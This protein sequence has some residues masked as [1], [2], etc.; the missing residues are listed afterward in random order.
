MD[1]GWEPVRNGDIYCSPR[2]GGKCKWD[3]YTHACDEAVTLAAIMKEA[4]GLDW[5]DRVHENLGW[6]YSV[7]L[8]AH[9]FGFGEGGMVYISPSIRHTLEERWILN[10]Y[11]CFFNAPGKQFVTKH[12]DPFRAFQDARNMADDFMIQ[13]KE[14]IAKTK[15]VQ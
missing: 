4:T 5:T 10:G 15:A 7:Y 3:D 13:M 14:F 12:D 2:C 8:T 11:T 9:G 1:K 6:H